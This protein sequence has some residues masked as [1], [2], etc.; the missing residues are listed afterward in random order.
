MVK[1]GSRVGPALF[2]GSTLPALPDATHG[3]TC[4][5]ARGAAPY[6]RSLPHRLPVGPPARA[7]YVLPACSAA[8]TVVGASLRRAVRRNTS[9]L[10]L[11][12]PLEARDTAGVRLV[13][14][15]I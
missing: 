2:P 12:D 6:A 3:A 4:H 15:E 10:P 5:Q 11:T 8:R 7:A 1:S 13:Q 14:D 9:P